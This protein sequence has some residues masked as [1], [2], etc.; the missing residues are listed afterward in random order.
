M[1]FSREQFF[2]LFAIYTIVSQ[3]KSKVLDIVNTYSQ[4]YSNKQRGILEI[5]N[6]LVNTFPDNSSTIEISDE[7]LQELTGILEQIE[8][9]AKAK[10]TELSQL[11]PKVTGETIQALLDQMRALYKT[12][13]QAEVYANNLRN[14][15]HLTLTHLNI[16]SFYISHRSSFSADGKYFAKIYEGKLEI[17]D[18]ETEKTIS[19]IRTPTDLVTFLPNGNLLSFTYAN[20]LSNKSSI[21]F[22]KV[23]NLKGECLDIWE[24]DI[25][26]ATWHI[27]PSGNKIVISREPLMFPNNHA[28]GKHTVLVCD[29]INKQI[30][31]LENSSWFDSNTFLPDGSLVESFNL[32][33]LDLQTGAKT[34]LFPQADH[35]SQIISTRR[36][37]SVGNDYLLSY[38]ESSYRM[39]LWNWRTHTHL[40]TSDPIFKP[41]P[42]TNM[43]FSDDLLFIRAFPNSPHFITG[44]HDFF[45]LWEITP[46]LTLKMLLKHKQ[47]DDTDNQS[48]NVGHHVLPD[49]RF[50]LSMGT[51][52]VNRNNNK[53]CVFEFADVR[54]YRNEKRLEERIDSSKSTGNRYGF[55]APVVSKVQDEVVRPGLVRRHSI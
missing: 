35:H 46:E 44:F 7:A 42:G 18:L 2:H 40:A 12:A 49:G 38:H 31:P 53:V 17:T 33:R 45:V 26:F 14:A 10:R 29:L 22:F 54:K 41:E 1:K 5:L 47:L 21:S 9:Q 8:K 27:S 25:W 48:R 39:L 32:S 23:W 24:I 20:K 55:L 15:N 43:T 3:H 13:N 16:G 28:Y 4:A 52:Y 51:D 34:P 50:V 6:S 11:I 37:A 36:V 30:K 19:S